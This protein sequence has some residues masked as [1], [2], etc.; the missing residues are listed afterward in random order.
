MRV[1]VFWYSQTGNS[2]LCGQKICE[3][4]RG[5]GCTV[6]FRSMRN[7]QEAPLDADLY[8]FTFP[9]FMW[10]PPYTVE[11]FIRAL[12]S[13]PQP[14][15]ALA[16]ITYA[17]AQ[18]NTA[19]ILKR[20]LAEKNIRLVDN[21]YIRAQDS[22]IFLKKYWKPFDRL[23]LPNIQSFT[24]ITQ[25]LSRNEECGYQGQRL[26][27][28]PFNILH[29]IGAL[30]KGRPG[31]IVLKILMGSRIID[32]SRCTGCAICAALCPTGA[33][34]MRDFKA[35][36]NISDCMGCNGCINICPAHAW[37]LTLYGPKYYFQGNRGASMMKALREERVK[38]EHGQ[39]D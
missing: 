33:I 1:T 37:R 12:P 19:I 28:N 29:W 14:Q 24:R 5:K 18:G 6:D 8:V 15:K 4:Y 20:R 32:K 17:S 27:F 2:F 25:F 22:N 35:Q 30:L 3:Y 38:D 39:R 21:L 7:A 36:C 23:D 13:F 11:K 34:S 10:N 31:F 9:V 16:V 26:W